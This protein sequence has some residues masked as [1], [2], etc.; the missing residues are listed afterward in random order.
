V[1]RHTIIQTIE[2]YA[3]ATQN[4]HMLRLLDRFRGRFPSRFAPPQS[5]K[6]KPAATLT[7]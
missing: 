4:W 6:R 2:R 7:A 1:G 3:Q 5:I